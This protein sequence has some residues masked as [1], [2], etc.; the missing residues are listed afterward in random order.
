MADLAPN[1]VGASSI[2]M[3]QA[4]LGASFDEARQVR[5]VFL[6]KSYRT[7]SGR[8]SFYEAE[9]ASVREIEL[10][11][12]ELE[13]VAFQD[14][15]L[16]LYQAFE[17]WDKIPDDTNNL[18]FVILRST[19]F[20][21]RAASVYEGIKEYQKDINHKI[22]QQVDSVNKIGKQISDLNKEI[23]SIEAAGVEKANDLRDTR[24]A[25]IDELSSYINVE[26]E[27]QYDGVL[28]IRAELKNPTTSL[29]TGL[30]YSGSYL[31]LSNLV[32]YL[33]ALMTL[34]AAISQNGQVL[35]GGWNHHRSKD[36]WK[37]LICCPT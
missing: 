9:Y 3:M 21:E 29:L 24:N 2:S 12:G 37:I 6:D 15:L 28:F 1:T 17:E 20:L 30:D 13:G 22:T 32:I 19:E 14:S 23:L 35:L 25:L 5:D 10:Y 33:I 7:E 8:Q 11:F 31:V 36:C 26:V 4:G 27:Q 34:K 18:D 16:G